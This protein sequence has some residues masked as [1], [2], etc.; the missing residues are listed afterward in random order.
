[1][2]L[3]RR[4]LIHGVRDPSSSGTTRFAQEGPIMLTA[5]VLV[6]SLAVTHDLRESNRDNAVQVVR[7]PEEFASPEACAMHGQAFLATTSIGQELT[8]N[9]RIKVL[10]IRRTG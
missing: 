3:A 9:E 10:C 1:M 6:C 8:D 5:L 7:V 4:V 2:C